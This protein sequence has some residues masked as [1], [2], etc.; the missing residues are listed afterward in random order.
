[1]HKD[2]TAFAKMP[3][4]D[5]HVHFGAAGGL[6]GISA[7]CDVIG[8]AG[9]ERFTVLCTLH[10]H[11]ANL[12]AVGIYAK[13]RYPAQIYLFGGL[14]HASIAG[15]P[16]QEAAADLATQVDRLI[17]LGC[18]G[19][20]MI[21]GKPMVYKML[22]FPFDGLLYS[23]LFSHLE[24]T[25][26]PLL[27]HVN[28][29]EEFWS[30]ALAPAW[31][32]ERNW[33]YDDGTYPEKETL[34]AQVENVLRRCPKLKVILAHFYFLSADLPRAAALL[35]RYDN[36]HFDITPGSEMYGNFSRNPEATRDFFIKYQ[37]R[38]LFGTDS[39]ERRLSPAPEGDIIAHPML[40]TFWRMRAFLETD[41]VQPAWGWPDKGEVRGIAL[42]QEALEKIYYRNFERLVGRAP[43]PLNR[44]QAIAECERLADLFERGATAWPRGGSLLPRPSANLAR[45]VAEF[46]KDERGKV[47]DE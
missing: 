39:N 21:E 29:P 15:K 37:D 5:C 40:G 17:A 11:M 27:F 35:D 33:V 38:I 22:P 4:V 24:Q 28:D 45:E 25:G 31:A 2:F 44:E 34:Y 32:K 10:P 6:E 47:R 3:V 13:A 12:N 9:V 1:M 19:L 20:K 42:P 23:D 7:M 41:R 18:D 26:F 8:Q 14:D 36:V 43:A 30:A 46:L 16:P